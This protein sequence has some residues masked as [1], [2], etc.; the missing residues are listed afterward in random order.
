MEHIDASEWKLKINLVQFPLAI[1]KFLAQE[2]GEIYITLS[3]S[4]PTSI[5]KNKLK[6]KSS[7]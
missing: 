4:S 3:C 1:V 5:K 6:K 2:E 7:S